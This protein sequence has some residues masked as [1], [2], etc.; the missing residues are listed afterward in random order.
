MTRRLFAPLALTAIASLT[1]GPAA[2]GQGFLI[3]RHAI[4]PVA[5]AFEIREVEIDA[6][7]RDQVAEVQVAQTFHNP[8]S[9]DLE[10]EFLF[11][12]PEDGAIQNFVLMVDGREMPGRLLPKDEARKIYEDIV[13]AKRDPAL[14]EYMGRGLFKTSV[15]PIPAGADR[16]VTMRYAQLCRRDKDLVEFSYPLATQKFTARPIRR[17]AISARIESRDPIKSLYS[18][19]HDAEVKRTGDHEA[20]VSYVGHDVIPTNDFRMMYSLAQGSLGATLLSYRPSEGE[21]GYFLLLASPDVPKRDE[22]P[23][24][25]TVVFVLDRSGSMAGKK[26]EQARNALK[27]VLDNL[28]DDDLFNIVVYDDRVETYKPEL[29]RYSRESRQDASRFV[30]NIRP[31]GSTNIADA[32]KAGLSMVK[33]DFRPSYVLFL[34]DGLPTAGETRETAI[35]D[36][37]KSSNPSRSRLFSFG[38]GFDVNARL[39][40]RLSGGNGGTSEYVRPDEDLETHVGRFYAKMS[41]PALS[42]LSVTLA[43]TDVN[44]TYPRDLPDLFDGGQLTWVGRYRDSGKTTVKIEGKV[45]GERTTHEFP[46]D[47]ENSHGTRRYEFVEKLW[48]VRRVGDIIDQIDLH[49]QNKELTDELVAL[50]TRYG[51][52]TP[53]TSFLAD[54]RVQLHAYRENF[55][56]TQENLRNLGVVSDVAGVRQRAAKG[57]YQMAQRAGDAS[58]FGLAYGGRDGAAMA[59][60]MRG[61]A[62][63]PTLAAPLA[64]SAGLPGA[65]PLAM[66][67]VPSPANV[68]EVGGRTFFRKG[69]RWVQSTIKP[70]DEARAIEIEQFSDSY[71]ELARNQTAESNQLLTFEE[72]VTVELDG[73]IYRIE[74]PKSR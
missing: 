68:R 51:I 38:V 63:P 41:S 25:K 31:G 45:D 47:L 16:K 72:P 24:P 20:T 54:E 6:R 55:G 11:P 18:P 58:S 22:K 10:S 4:A 49:G 27:S 74:R 37:A 48:A 32:L 53:Y 36:L 26:I 50:S 2:R 14:L 1:T 40:D 66:P 30:E 71:F 3:D 52:M 67:S 59:G 21:D 33:D 46:A 28:R 70:E 12:L 17:L 29:Q 44:R 43:G 9:A 19:S 35:A 15:F 65:V 57:S 56:Q 7:I 34:T 69:D 8:G 60:G 73:K 64:K 23:Q 61:A 62:S 42:G 5:R 39:L 13:R